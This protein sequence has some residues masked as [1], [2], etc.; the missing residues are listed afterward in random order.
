MLIT[1]TPEISAAWQAMWSPPPRK[2]QESN[3]FRK[4]WG[5]IV[6]LLLLYTGSGSAAVTSYPIPSM[7]DIFTYIW[8][9]LMVNVGEYTRHG[10]YGYGNFLTKW[11]LYVSWFCLDMGYFPSINVGVV[12]SDVNQPLQLMS[13]H[14]RLFW[15]PSLIFCIILIECLAQKWDPSKGVVES[16]KHLD[17]FHP[18]LCDSIS[19]TSGTSR[20]SHRKGWV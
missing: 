20:K 1:M 12:H 13:C 19:G 14:G 2:P 7:Y 15:R 3:M 8:L 10:S 9:I 16:F 5:F 6:G 18:Q 17:D 11:G 4:F